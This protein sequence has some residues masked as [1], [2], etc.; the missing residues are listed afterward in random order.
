MFKHSTL[1]I[2]KEPDTM[3]RAASIAQLLDLEGKNR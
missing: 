1:P 2:M 3:L